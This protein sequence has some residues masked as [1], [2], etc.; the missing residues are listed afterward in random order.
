MIA[1]A[2]AT[3]LAKPAKLT[4]EQEEFIRTKLSSKYWRM[5][6]LYKIRDKS[7]NLVTMKLNAAQ[8][9][10]LKKFKHNRKIILKS[11]QQGISTLYLAYNL[12]DCLFKE[13]YQAGI[14]SYGQDE[15]DKLS[16]RAELM[17]NEF[18]EDIKALFNLGLTS[19]NQ[20]GMTFSNGS[21]LKIGNFRGDT[22]QS[23][24]V[25]EL[26]KIAKK[27]PEKAK[28]LKTGAFQ[29][30]SVNNKITIESTAEGRSG[31]FYEMWNKAEALQLQGKDLSPLEF[32][33]IFLSWV[34]D[35]DCRLDHETDI[36]KEL[37]QYFLDIETDLG[38]K[39]EMN[40]KWWY[41][42]KKEEL[43][44]DMTQEYPTTAEEAF[45]AAKDG[46]YYGRAYRDYILK[47]KRLIKDLYDPML[48][49]H[50]AYDLGYNDTMVAI[51]YQQ[52]T[53]G[54]RI[55]DSYSNSGESIQHY[56]K[57]MDDKRD[58]LGYRYAKFI[59]LPHDAEVHDLNEGKTRTDTFRKYGYPA[60]V[61]PKISVEEGIELVREWMK[62]MW[63]DSSDDYVQNTFINYMKEWDDKL[64][65]WKKKPLHN[66]WSNPAD[67]IRYMCVALRQSYTHGKK[68]R[69]KKSGYAI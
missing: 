35:L 1:N 65:T 52:F 39:L 27:Y 40:Q 34:E 43:E 30:V 47:Q 31:L 9:K 44:E 58:K 53:D 3:E 11:R 68:K 29:A 48:D 63:I 50:V 22:L 19:N 20:K 14:Q 51:F 42:A 15:A 46:S 4:L 17:W 62:K 67:A 61:L 10:V 36:S 6:N 28:E 64:G 54:V 18:P 7:G 37:A 2:A 33:A 56:T 25:S 26:G 32:Q 13:G 57:M 55:I 23:L 45:M 69:R 38:V 8:R 5:N 21:I 66:E 16:K 12:D 59:N 49:V 41:A 60:R 24:H